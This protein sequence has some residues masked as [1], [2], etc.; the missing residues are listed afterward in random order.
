M[1]KLE[2]KKLAG[3]ERDSNNN[4]NEISIM[5]NSPR[6][7]DGDNMPVSDRNKTKSRNESFG[8]IKS[9]L[10]NKEGG[11]KELLNQ[12]ITNN[13]KPGN[14]K[15]TIMDMLN[16]KENELKNKI[17]KLNIGNLTDKKNDDNKTNNNKDRTKKYLPDINLG[18]TSGQSTERDKDNI[19][20]DIFGVKKKFHGIKE[21]NNNNGEEE[22]FEDSE[23][24]ESSINNNDGLGGDTISNN[25]DLSLSP[26]KK[27]KKK[28]SKKSKKNKSKGK[29]IKKK[30]RVKSPSKS[31]NN[32]SRNSNNKDLSEASGDGDGEFNMEELMEQLALIEDDDGED[33]DNDNE[34][35]SDNDN[36]EKDIDSKKKE[37]LVKEKQNI[38]QN[39]S[40]MINE[41]N[42]MNDFLNGITLPSEEGGTQGS[43]NASSSFPQPTTGGL[44]GLSLLNEELKK[45]ILSKIPDL[46]ELLEIQN[47][48]DDNIKKIQEKR[49]QLKSLMSNYYQ[50]MFKSQATSVFNKNNKDLKDLRNFLKSKFLHKNNNDNNNNNENALFTFASNE[51]DYD[52]EGTPLPLRPP[53][54]PK[55][56]KKHSKYLRNLHKKLA[57]YESMAGRDKN[58]N[59]IFDN[60][61]L[62][63]NNKNNPEEVIKL[64][65]E[66]EEILRTDY[67]KIKK[68]LKK[69]DVAKKLQIIKKEQRLK[70][71]AFSKRKKQPKVKNTLLCT[72]D[73]EDKQDEEEIKRKQKEKE[74]EEEK[75]RQEN[76]KKRRL[77][78][79][80]E[81]IQ[82][83]KNGNVSDFE[84]ELD[85]LID[86]QMEQM[87]GKIEAN[88]QRKNNFMQDFYLNRVKAKFT[89]NF[90]QKTIGY[91]SPIIFS[92]GESNTTGK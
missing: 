70:K 63:K 43:N 82:N 52:E 24:D 22:E 32:I 49:S 36:N 41:L 28:K 7:E 5:D 84:L 12:D 47:K 20:K 61:Y 40:Q 42:E 25:N 74:E 51:Q 44:S 79:F 23:N 11:D 72:D 35:E 85:N 21:N 50:K 62:L 31:K 76:L 77:Y 3:N 66:V 57:L 58:G 56:K 16:E 15:T 34:N 13:S 8:G 89:M 68:I 26:S 45:E 92:T 78:D 29:N 27:K 38:I 2:L 71:R 4:N 18:G 14:N 53:S 86:E 91:M 67:S 90:R 83:L 80:F 48:T 73:M 33:D 59:L 60:S 39:K 87:G 10:N 6:G 65:K 1:K 54:L 81:K 88:E 37:A 69:T 46:R 17:T 30:V 64:R 55:K 9:I 75:K 19:N